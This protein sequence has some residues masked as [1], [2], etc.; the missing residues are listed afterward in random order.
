[1]TQSF[2]KRAL[3]VL[4]CA[5][6]SSVAL[7]SF[8]DDWKPVDGI[9]LS[10]FAK[11]VSPEKAWPEYPRPQMTRDAWVNLNGLWDYKIVPVEKEFVKC[12]TAPEFGKADGQILVPYCIESALSGVGKRVGK[13][14][15]LLYNKTLEIPADWEGKE[16]M[17][18]F[19]AVDW[20]CDVYLNNVKVGSHQGGYCPFTVN[21]TPAINK[22]GVQNLVVKVCDPTNEGPQGIGKQINNPHG[23]WYTPVTGIWQSVWM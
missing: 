6:A 22:D 4:V 23:I 13:D 12:D 20:R 14:N 10:K 8:A 18:N 3:A 17:L 11:D 5:V 9:L 16:I 15:Y 19:G 7:T 2:L 21:L 1:M